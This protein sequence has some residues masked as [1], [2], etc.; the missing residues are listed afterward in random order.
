MFKRFSSSVGGGE[1]NSSPN[2]MNSADPETRFTLPHLRY[3]SLE[4]G[5]MR[6][7]IALLAHVLIFSPSLFALPW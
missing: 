7:M 5:L 2:S 4:R 3:E 1:K 6:L